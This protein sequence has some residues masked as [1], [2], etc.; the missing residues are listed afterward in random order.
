MVAWIL[1]GFGQLLHGHV[2]RRHVRIPEAQIDH[3]LAG[4]AQLELEP[5]DLGERVRRQRTDPAK[6]DLERPL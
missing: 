6:P 1:R 2:G 4:A 3:V 5:V